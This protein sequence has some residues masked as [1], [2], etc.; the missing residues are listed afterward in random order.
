MMKEV[1]EKA[2]V[3]PPGPPKLA[4]TDREI[5]ELFIARLRRQIAA[6]GAEAEGAGNA[7]RPR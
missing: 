4:A 5:V 1:N 3:A 7:D 2:S 6:E